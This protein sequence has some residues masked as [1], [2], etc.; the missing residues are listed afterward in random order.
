MSKIYFRLGR[1]VFAGSF[2]PSGNIV[3]DSITL[4]LPLDLPSWQLDNYHWG[5]W[6]NDT[7]SIEFGAGSFFNHQN[8][9]TVQHSFRD[10][11]PQSVWQTLAHTTYITTPSNFENNYFL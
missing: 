11:T 10:H 5:T 4:R 9:S 7:L 3:E 1:G 6:D 2:I 8:P